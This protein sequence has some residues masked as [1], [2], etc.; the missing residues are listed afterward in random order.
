MEEQNQPNKKFLTG[1]PSPNFDEGKVPKDVI[2]KCEEA[3]ADNKGIFLT[4]PQG[5]GKTT[6][7]RKYVSDHPGIEFFNPFKM[8]E[9]IAGSSKGIYDRK[10]SFYN[11]KKEIVIDNFGRENPAFWGYSKLD[12]WMSVV[13][14]FRYE[15]YINFGTLTHFTSNSLPKQISERYGA[16]ILDR[17]CQMS[18]IVAYTRPDGSLRIPNKSPWNPKS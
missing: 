14:N 6:L 15:V 18:N 7:I 9:E 11:Q 5:T 12:D 13:I 2:K 16:D 17:I 3:L 4:G 8:C 10:L 1:R